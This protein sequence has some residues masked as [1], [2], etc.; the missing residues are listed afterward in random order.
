VERHL[1]ERLTGAAVL[2]A[3]AVI[4]IPE[5]L[6]GPDQIARGT[7]PAPLAGEAPTKTYTIDLSRSPGVQS[8][9]A[10]APVVQER[11]PPPETAANDSVPAASNQ[12]SPE[13]TSAAPTTAPP[14]TPSP[15]VVTPEQTSPAATAPEP[16]PTRPVQQAAVESPAPVSA[17][18]NKPTAS[19]GWAVQLGS[20]SNQATAGNMVR[21]LRADGYDAFVMPVKS[22]SATL[23]RVRIGP[24]NDRDA[25]TKILGRIKATVPTAAV[26]RHP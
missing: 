13:S 5:M 17:G 19:G 3:A 8:S 7:A 16:A 26:V 15:A 21:Q 9:A 24:V 6:S 10:S 23:Y 20:F 4:L 25:A 22:G 18:D 12:A 2:I 11:A 14:V 1:K